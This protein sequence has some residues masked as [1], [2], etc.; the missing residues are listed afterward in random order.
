M[1]GQTGDGNNPTPN[2]EHAENTDSTTNLRRTDAPS[3]S[4]EAVLERGR[5]YTREEL[6]EFRPSLERIGKSMLEIIPMLFD[7]W[8]PF[9]D[10]AYAK[11]VG[12]PVNEDGTITTPGMGRVP[13]RELCEE[14][15]I[16]NMLELEDTRDIDELEKLIGLED[17]R[18]RG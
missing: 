9:P 3:G 17:T 8:C 5:N 16:E 10:V 2:S 18:D 1:E 6:M 4:E 11:S 12:W 13:S 15:R 14:S 7:N